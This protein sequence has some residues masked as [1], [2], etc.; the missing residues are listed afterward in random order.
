MIVAATA[1][2]SYCSAP[3]L[4]GAFIFSL[5]TAYGAHFRQDEDRMRGAMNQ[6]LEDRAAGASGGFQAEEI[7]RFSRLSFLMYVGKID[8]KL[9]CRRVTMV[10]K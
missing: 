1:S 9:L 5:K 2:R 10:T 7:N 8:S 4:T 3:A 6:R